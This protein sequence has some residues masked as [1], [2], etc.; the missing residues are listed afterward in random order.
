VGNGSQAEARRL[1]AFHID[2][3]EGEVAGG[4]FFSLTKI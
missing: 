4:I 1:T 2:F 3:G